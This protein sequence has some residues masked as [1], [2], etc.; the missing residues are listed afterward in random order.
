MDAQIIAAAKKKTL[1]IVSALKKQGEGK[2]LTQAEQRLIEKSGGYQADYSIGELTAKCDSDWK[3]VA[4]AV[5]SLTPVRI[6]GR[7]KFYRLEDVQA[8]MAQRRGDKGLKDQKLE[9]EIRR[10]RLANDKQ[11]GLSV[12]RKVVASLLQELSAGQLALLRQRM[13]NEAPSQ[14]A[15]LKDPA[16]VRIINKRIVDE[17]C[18]KMRALVKDWTC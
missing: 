14:T 6:K 12:S 4:K 18:E 16:A 10:L 3:T 17:I 11:E 7:Q 13:E 15:D 8:A 2:A 5:G 1:D 9:Q